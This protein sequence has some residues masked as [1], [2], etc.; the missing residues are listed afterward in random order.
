MEDSKQRWRR[1]SITACLSVWH[2]QK[3]K[4]GIT[5]GSDFCNVRIHDVKLK[6]PQE[7]FVILLLH[8]TLYAVQSQ[9]VHY[10]ISTWLYTAHT[11]LLRHFLKIWHFSLCSES[12]RF[13]SFDAETKL[14]TITVKFPSNR[15][16]LIRLSVHYNYTMCR[17]QAL[18]PLL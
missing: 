11:A 4:F 6:L 8:C 12:G 5:L 13:C 15:Y 2:A 14:Y 17:L 10:T 9:A 18:W 16:Y 7:L 1:S 3:I